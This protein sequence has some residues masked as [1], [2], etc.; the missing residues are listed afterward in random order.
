MIAE[1]FDVVYLYESYWWYDFNDFPIY[2]TT[3][4]LWTVELDKEKL[5]DGN[6][7][8]EFR[9][10]R[11]YANQLSYTPIVSQNFTIEKIYE[12]S[13]VESNN[14]MVNGP[15]IFISGLIV[16]SL[17][18]VAVISRKISLPK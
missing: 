4:G 7:T 12:I 9:V 17:I 3:G 5:K 14:G 1:R 8:I 11:K 6:H 16:L 2:P 18:S 15:A 10:L 13:L